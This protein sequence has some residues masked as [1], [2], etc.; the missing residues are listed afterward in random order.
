M[1][2]ARKKSKRWRRVL[3]VILLLGVLGV[4][5][6]LLFTPAWSLI[7]EAL[8]A[9]P[10][11][12]EEGECDHGTFRRV[13]GVGVLTLWGTPYQRGFAHGKLLARGI[14]DMVD[15][16]GGS[17]LLLSD[18][19]DYE[20]KILPLV[21]RFEFEPA[22][23]E[24]LRGIFEGVQAA[25]GPRPMLE[26]LGRPPTLPDLKACNTA[27]DWYRQACAT[28]AAWGTRAKGK[29]V[30]VGRNFDFLPAKASV[31]HQMIVVHK[32]LGEKKAWATVSAPGMI[33]CITGLNEDGVFASVHDV[34]LP[35]RRLEKGYSPRLLVLRRL[36]ETCE[37]RDLEGQARPI[38]EARKPMFDNAILLAAPVA[39]GS[40][41]AVVFEYNSDY[42]KDKGVTVRTPADNEEKL[43]REMITCTN[44]FRKRLKPGFNLTYYRYPLMRRVLMAK[45]NR[46]LKVDIDIARKTMGAV[47]L[48][49]TV[50]TVIADLNTLDFWFA[51]GEFLSPPGHRDYV[52]LPMREWLKAE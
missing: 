22:D 6:L 1:S 11:A 32:R 20:K 24:E 34:F 9:A 14:L 21:G 41:P 16:V 48:P 33:G 25:L 52:K 50:H 47:R 36:M 3:R 15:V 35:L 40:P 28:F 31:S 7:R 12:V 8:S 38:L 17:N 23:E 13:K 44:H 51:A 49:I 39:D 43:S 30:W 18:T 46:G 29:H 10:A 26:Q 19:E 27:G 42:S 45:T 5:A 4:A 2:A 37:P